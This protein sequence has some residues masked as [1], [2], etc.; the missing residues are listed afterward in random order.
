M[1]WKH[2]V[3]TAAHIHANPASEHPAFTIPGV[4]E[5]NVMHDMLHVADV[6][7]VSAHFCGTAL[8]TFV[9]F[10][11]D[12]VNRRDAMGRVWECIQEVYAQLGIR[13]RFTNLTLSMII[14]PQTPWADYPSLKGKGAEVRHLVPVIYQLTQEYN[15]GSL[16][17][18]LRMYAAQHL[19]RIYDILK[20][21]ETEQDLPACIS[22]TS[23]WRR[24]RDAI[25]TNKIKSRRLWIDNKP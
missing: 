11:S 4:T 2:E 6:N 1:Q 14:S 17:D 5:L 20:E 15:R 8:F 7:G 12:G 16:H 9:F 18:N 23:H 25:K 24:Q 10:D 3:F 19:C 13:Q 22:A 21:N